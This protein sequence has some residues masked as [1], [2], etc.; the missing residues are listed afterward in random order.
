[1]LDQTF[2]NHGHTAVNNS[3]EVIKALS[4]KLEPYDGA[5]DVFLD[6]MADY[7]EY[8]SILADN[9]SRMRQL[10]FAFS[11]AGAAY[12]YIGKNGAKSSHPYSEWDNYHPP[13]GIWGGMGI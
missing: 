10:K 1:M 5:R 9:K 12:K 13:L 7:L 4:H 6:Y 8:V 3:R 11:L 2:H